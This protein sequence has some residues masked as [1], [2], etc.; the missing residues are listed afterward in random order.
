MHST[1]QPR[2]HAQPQTG[3]FR[4]VGGVKDLTSDARIVAATN[5]DLAAMS[6]D[7]RFRQD[8]YFRLSAFSVRLPPL[9]ERRDD[10]PMLAAHFL[11]KHD[12]SRRFKKELSRA[13]ERALV[14]YD[15]PGNVRELRNVMERSIILSRLEPAI[16]VRHLGLPAA[17]GSGQ[18]KLSFRH[19]ASLD[20]V[21]QAYV[22]LLHALFQPPHQ[23]GRSTRRQ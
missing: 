6:K 17:P 23:A 20:E 16:H 10:I 13:A 5:R 21:K 15:W 2:P 3:H 9:R 8:L 1:S 19:E 12:F 11:E 18:V 22:R 4:R 7:G 14:A